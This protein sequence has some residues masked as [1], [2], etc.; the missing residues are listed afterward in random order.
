MDWPWARLRAWITGLIWP[1]SPARAIITRRPRPCPLGS[2]VFENEI[3][4]WQKQASKERV[5]EIICLFG[6]RHDKTCLQGFR[7][8]ETNQ[9]PQLQR[10]ARTLKFRLKHAY[11]VLSKKGITRRWSVCCSQTPEDRFTC[12]EAHLILFIECIR[13]IFKV[14]SDF[15]DINK[16]E[17]IKKS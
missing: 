8:S 13:L 15:K 11:M 16:K 3:S 10:L 14:H 2:P 7:E 12:L 5:D 1:S 4:R 6:P 17:M 9:S